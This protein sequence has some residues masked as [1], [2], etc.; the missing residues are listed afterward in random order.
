MS[1]DAEEQKRFTV[2]VNNLPSLFPTHRHRPMFWETLG[3]TIATFGFLEEV[4]GKAIFAF[5]ATTRHQE[6]EIDA[7]F[8]NW[9][10]TLE[11]AL[12]DPLGSLIDAYGKAVRNNSEATIGNLDELLCELR[13]ASVIRNV[14]CH[15]SWRAPDADGRSLPLF[16]NRQKMVWDMPIDTAYLM[17][18]QKAVAELGC[19]V[20]QTVTHMGWQFP[21]SR[22]PGK[23]IFEKP[24]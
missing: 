20:I 1:D 17:Q 16:V 19:A 22:G 6:S 10:P 23:A 7:A 11:R 13:D 24:A 18:T 12:I 8:E 9:L 5:T 4:L 21:G 14:L 15:G 2:D 3:R